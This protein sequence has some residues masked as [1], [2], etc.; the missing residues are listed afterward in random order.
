MATAASSRDLAAPPAP[1]ASA[2]ESR[3]GGGGGLGSGGGARPAREGGGDGESERAEPG[4]RDKAGPTEREEERLVQQSLLGGERRGEEKNLPREGPG[5]QR[6]SLH[7]HCSLA[8][9]V[10][11][12]PIGGRGLRPVPGDKAPVDAERGGPGGGSPR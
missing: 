9:D 1:L 11:E 8:S 6:G 7:R 3:W 12:A 2:K 5:E 4:G 10:L